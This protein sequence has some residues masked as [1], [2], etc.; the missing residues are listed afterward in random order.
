VKKWEGF[1][2]ILHGFRNLLD[3]QKD[4]NTK[5]KDEVTGD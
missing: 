3:T 4:T 1:D 2:D 5:V